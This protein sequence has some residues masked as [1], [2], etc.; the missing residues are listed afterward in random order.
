M[1]DWLNDFD[2]STIDPD[3][4]RAAFP[5]AVAG[6]IVWALWLYRVILSAA[7][8]ADRQRLPHHDLGGGAVLSARTRTSCMRCLRNWLAQDPT[9]VIIVLDVADTEALRTDHRARRPAGAGRSCSSTP[10][11]A[12]RSASASGPRR[13]EI[14]VLVD[15]DTRWQPG[16]LA[17]VQMPFVD[18]EVGG[19]RHPAE[20]VPA[21]HQR[22]AADRRLAGQP[23]LLRLRAGDGPGRR[24]R[25]PVRAH[26]RLPARGGHAG[27]GE[28]GERVLPRP[29]LRRRRR[30]PA[31]LAG[32]GLGLQD[33]APVLG[34]GA[35]DVPRLV[36]GL[37][38]AAGAVEPQLLPL[39]P[40]RAVQ[41]LAVAGPVRHQDHR[42]ADPAH[43]GD[44]GHD[45]RL[46][47]VQPPGADRGPA[48]SL[49]LVWLLRRPRHPRVLAP[50][51]APA[52]DPAAAAAGAGRHHDR[53]ADQALRLRDHEQAG[54]A[55]PA[56]RTASAARART[57][58]R[59]RARAAATCPRRTN[60]RSRAP[61]RSELARDTR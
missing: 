36:P 24:G 48:S 37:R 47:V 13:G 54:L 2:L 29:P 25:L 39:L 22:L 15:S 23:A 34:P 3:Q 40:D 26:R 1:P 11:S 12:P 58:R 33:R 19:G 5:L 8:Q 27:A 60:R 61:R 41:G 57:R 17:A 35:V 20:R 55:D 52:G 46:P 18:P 31:D 50:A 44:H 28:P 30:R 32:A 16:L 10:A 7:G 59:W 21:H 51:P 9:E 56:P 38:Q 42:A 45:P 4:L 6:V 53:A 43:P 49:A 14:V